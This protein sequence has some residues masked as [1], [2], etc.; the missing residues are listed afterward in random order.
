M[1]F[2]DSQ[3]LRKTVA[4]ACMFLAPLLFV[5]AFVVSPK[6]ETE[7]G[8]TLRTAAAHLDRYLV[9]NILGMVGLILLIPAV[10][11]L[12]HMLRE[13]RPVY[14]AVGGAL[15][16]IGLVASMAGVGAGFVIWGMAKDGVQPADVS[17]LH[18]VSHSA[19]AMIPLYIV[20]LVSAVGLVVMAAGLYLSRVVDWWMALF[21]ATGAVCINVAFPAGELAVGIVGAALMLVG[22]GSVGL[23][24]LRASDADPGHTP[25]YP[26]LRPA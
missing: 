15:S 20:G 18:T 13:R 3:H 22:L 5:V 9:S 19:E 4:G 1:G 14:G 21:V 10:L 8:P 25:G 2:S 26:R 23:M 6:L 7:A 16:I 17:A 12:M 11:G 24:G